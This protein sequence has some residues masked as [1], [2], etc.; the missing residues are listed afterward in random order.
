M[1]DSAFGR[2]CL[3]ANLDEKKLIALNHCKHLKLKYKK[4]ESVDKLNRDRG[5]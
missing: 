1:N 5:I 4:K 2:V 3:C